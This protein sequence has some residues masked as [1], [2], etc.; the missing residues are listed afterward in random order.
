MPLNLDLPATGEAP[1]CK[2]EAINIDFTITTD[3]SDISLW[4]ITF[5]VKT[6]G[7]VSKISQVCTVMDGLD[8]TVRLALTHDQLNIPAGTYT[9][10]LWRTDVGS[11]TC[12][13][14]GKFYLTQETLY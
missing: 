1:I 14:F 8:K 12:L 3:Y 13:R 10:D 9:Y 11:E 7:G 2:G 5:T 4:T 6:Q